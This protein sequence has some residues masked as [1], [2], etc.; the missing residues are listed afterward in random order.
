MPDLPNPNDPFQYPTRQPPAGITSFVNGAAPP[1]AP[2]EIDKIVTLEEGEDGSIHVLISDH[3][4]EPEQ[5]SPDDTF[6]ENLAERDELKGA[7]MG[8]ASDLI[9]GIEADDR[10]RGSYVENYNAGLDLLGLSIVGNKR[11]GDQMSSVTDTILLD[12]VLNFRALA[13][14]EILPA[15]GPVKVRNDGDET[16]ERQTLADDLE[17]DANHYMTVTATEYVPDTDRGLIYVAFGGDIFKKVYRCPVRKRPVSECVYIPD[18]IVSQEATDLA[19]A[20]RVTHRIEMTKTAVKRL[21]LAGQYVETELQEPSPNPPSIDRKE[22]E[23]QGISPVPQRQEDY[24]RTIYECYT[25][26]DLSQ[27]ITEK[28]A[29]E[30]LPL[31]YRVSIDKDAR[32]VLE[33]RRNWKAD[34][35]QFRKRKRFVKWPFMPGMGFYDLGY[36]HI[37]GQHAKALTA[38]LRIM[39]DAGMFANFPGGVMLKGTRTDTNQIRPGPGEWVMVDGGATADK[40]QDVLMPM[41]YKDISSTMLALYQAIKEDAR[42]LAGT[43]DLMAG[44]GRTDIPV[45]TMMAMIEQQTQMMT[46]VHKGLHSAQ[47]EELS[48]FREL[49]VEDPESL[50]RDNPQPT[51]KWKAEEL[52]DLSLVPASDPNTPAHIHRTMQGTALAQMSAGNELY[53]QYAVQKR[54]LDTIRISNPD[55]LLVQP[56]PPVQPPAPPPDPTLQ[57]GLGQL[58]N[59]QQKIQSDAAAKAA[60]LQV[61]SQKQMQDHQRA[62]ADLKISMQKYIDEN[63]NLAADRASREKIAEWNGRVQ[64]LLKGIETLGQ[65]TNPN[66]LEQGAAGP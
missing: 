48:M 7:L 66:A 62:M 63:D 37:I 54:L 4:D 32:T 45:G 59:E 29:P 34:D 40:I 36:L 13:R 50:W 53:N 12:T 5:S 57:L 65:T 47:A 19:N 23:V 25:E 10:S 26:L 33:I 18:L 8:I 24:Q 21:Q 60:Q 64:L 61:T 56:Q 42:K 44:D 52:E 35:D 11:V 15:D 31:P 49:W 30:D 43:V 22:K 14:G 2:D 1:L 3:P 46:A 17:Q 9:E 28:G 20:M 58:Q 41:P 51:R 16:D 39:I 27:W 38:L 6:D 55:E